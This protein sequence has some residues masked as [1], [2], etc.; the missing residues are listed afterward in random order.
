MCFGCLCCAA[1]DPFYLDFHS[2][3]CN[4]TENSEAPHTLVRLSAFRFGLTSSFVFVFGCAERYDAKLTTELS[5]LE[6]RAG[7]AMSHDREVCLTTLS[8]SHHALTASEE[9]LSP[10]LRHGALF[11]A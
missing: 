11:Y 7:H 2:G 9:T 10:D 6:V 3:S 8:T 4:S 5:A 1:E